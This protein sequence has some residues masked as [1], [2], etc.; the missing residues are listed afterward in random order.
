MLPK[1]L[2]GDFNMTNSFGY[3]QNIGEIIERERERQKISVKELCRGLC[4]VSTYTRYKYSQITPDLLT[5]T[6][7]CDRLGFNIDDMYI[8]CS[9]KEYLIVKKRTE[10]IYTAKIDSSKVSE[11][12]DHYSNMRIKRGQALCNQF[13]LLCKGVLNIN[14]SSTATNYFKKATVLT[15]LDIN[16]ISNLSRLHDLE[17]ELWIRLD[18]LNGFQQL[19]QI[20]DYIYNLNDNNILKKKYFGYISYVFAN[21]VYESNNKEEALQI[22]TKAIEYKRKI[23]QLKHFDIILEFKKKLSG[24]NLSSSEKHILNTIE[25]INTINNEVFNI[26]DE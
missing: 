24:N 14:D 9:E 3:N 13:I 6:A 7:L 2:I 8:A 20:Y 15:N 25:S 16:N 10:I 26:L 22:L 1:S 11:L 4:N 12:L 23:F 18:E 5:L 19:T 21:K 17:L